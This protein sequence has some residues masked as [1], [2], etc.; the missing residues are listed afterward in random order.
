MFQ[1]LSGKVALVT[2]GSSGLGRAIVHRLAADGASV[3]VAG[4]DDERTRAVATEA[5]EVA[6]RAG[7]GEAAFASVLGDVALVADCERLIAGALARLG[8]IDVLVNSAGIWIEKPITAM[9]EADYDLLMDVNLKGTYFMCRAAIRHMAP[10]RSGVIVNIASDSGTHGEPG[11]AAYAAS[12]A[13]VIMLTRTLAIDHGPDGVRVCSVSPAIFDTPMLTRAIAEADD[14]EAYASWQA[15]GYPLGRIG[16]PEELASVV[17]FLAS[18]E[19]SFVTGRTW[20]VD[21]GFTA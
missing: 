13:G 8:R 11:A 17:S 21:G 2:G 12:K 16:Q 20:T 3:V 7:F 9:S 6:A 10:R 5:A 18:D 1:G 15:D 4:R 19:A 14:P